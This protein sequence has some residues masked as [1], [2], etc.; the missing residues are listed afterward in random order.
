MSL[1]I[2][3]LDLRAP[4]MYSRN[5]MDDPFIQP[6]Y[7][8]EQIAC[9]SLDKEACKAIEP[10][11]NQFLGPILFTGI[12][13]NE[14]QEVEHCSI[15]KGLYLFAQLREFPN[16]ELFTAMAL[17]VQKEGLWRGLSMEP[18]VFMRV[19][20]EDDGLVTQVFRPISSNTHK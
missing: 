16:K 15:P 18:I 5:V 19:L 2:Y 11:I 9:F 3:T 6:I 17:E 10:D 4:F 12:Q 14:I 8:E 1:S 13:T 20:K 7:Y